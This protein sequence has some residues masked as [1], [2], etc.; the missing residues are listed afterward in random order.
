MVLHFLLLGMWPNSGPMAD[1]CRMSLS[2]LYI[3]CESS[4]QHTAVDIHLYPDAIGG[5]HDPSHAQEQS[6]SHGDGALQGKLPEPTVLGQVGCSSPKSG[7]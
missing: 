6:T 3:R 1:V 4:S 7:R 2:L 5:L